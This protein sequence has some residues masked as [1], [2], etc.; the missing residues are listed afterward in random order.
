MVRAENSNLFELPIICSYK[1]VLWYPDKSN[2][3]YIFWRMNTIEAYFFND[4][5]SLLSAMINSK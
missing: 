5:I 2:Q 4:L 1:G 3:N